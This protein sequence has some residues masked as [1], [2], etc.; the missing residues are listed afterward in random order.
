LTRYRWWFAGLLLLVLAGAAAEA[1]PPPAISGGIVELP[2]YTVTTSPALPPPERWRYATHSG[3]EILSNAADGATNLRVQEFLKFRQV[4]KILWP[5][6]MEVQKNVALI[7]CRR[8]DK[9]ADFT[10]P[11]FNQ[12][13]LLLPGRERAAIVI[14]LEAVVDPAGVELDHSRLLNRDYIRLLLGR[15][16]RRAPAWLEEGISQLFIE[17]EFTD[18]WIVFGRVRSTQNLPPNHPTGIVQGAG[19]LAFNTYFIDGHKRL[20]PLA[21]MFAVTHDSDT[22]QQAMGNR[23]WTKQAYAFVHMCL[24]GQNLRYRQ[25][26]MDFASRLDREPLSEALFKDCF[27]SD[28]AGMLDVLRGY[29]LHT[30]HKFARI[31]LAPGDRLTASPLSFREA[32]DGEVGRLKGDAQSLAGLNQAAPLTYRQAYMQGARDPDLLAAL[33]VAEAAAGN[34]DR[35]RA[36]LIAATKAGVDRPSAYVA[37]SRL[38]LAE[39]RAA[40]LAADGL[41]SGQQV[42]AVLTPLLEARNRPPALPETYELI[43]TTWTHSAVAPTPGNLAVLDEGIRAFPRDSALLYGA[44]R[45]YHQAGA[46][47]TAA[48]IARLGLRY[49]TDAAAQARFEE[50]LAALPPSPAKL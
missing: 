40:P 9:F 50:L 19:E 14:D 4:L 39:A 5:A 25:A 34:T 42:A 1:Q 27:K 32:T 7:L 16:G 2:T 46:Q 22:A 49:A 30:R 20:M 11:G 13:S 17:T 29:L 45:L 35:A 23:L 12:S 31:K 33:G 21:K 28:Y 37:L 47:A 26:L 15:N 38:L 24:C 18:D 43:A 3:V 41:L 44:A 48:S 36:F 6:P 10:P 8:G